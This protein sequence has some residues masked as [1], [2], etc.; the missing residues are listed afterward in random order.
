MHS[1][2]Y[3]AS[4]IAVAS[5]VSASASPYAGAPSTISCNDRIC[6]STPVTSRASRAAAPRRVILSRRGS[7]RAYTRTFATRTYAAR[8]YARR[9]TL[10]A[11]P[12]W[13]RPAFE[14]ADRPAGGGTV[15]VETA[16]NPITVAAGIAGPMRDLISDLV[17]DGFRG[18]VTCQA[19]G[20]MPGSLHHTGEAC[21]FAQ[22]RRNVVAPGAGI[23]YHASSI[24]TAH[25]LRDG[26]S[27]HDCGHVDTGRM[28]NARAQ[29]IPGAARLP[30][31]ARRYGGH[32]LYRVARRYWR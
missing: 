23:M 3:C 14:R 26:C 20:H 6:A 1:V 27:F 21:D 32:R 4:M 16:A 19:S 25:G 29:W 8:T 10:E 11:S 12:S 22:L 13:S 31:T 30:L 15:T 28:L 7:P 2:L 5:C 24:I 17:A 18:H 9:P